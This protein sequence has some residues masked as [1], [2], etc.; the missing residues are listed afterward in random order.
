MYKV[1]Y[2]NKVDYILSRERARGR[3]KEWMMRAD[4]KMVVRIASRIIDVLA[5]RY[6]I[7]MEHL[8][9]DIHYALHHQ[10]MPIR[11]TTIKHI[12]DDIRFLERT[13]GYISALN[14]KYYEKGVKQA[15]RLLELLSILLEAIVEKSENI[16]I[17]EWEKRCE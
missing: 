5:R 6:V 11:V 10:H 7:H 1:I 3:F 4:D 15:S 14:L 16:I 17:D 2:D 13:R 8:M 12:V 9:V